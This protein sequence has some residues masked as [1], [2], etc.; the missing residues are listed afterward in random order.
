MTGVGRLRAVVR[1]VTTAP[2]LALIWC[3]QHLISPMT[4]PTCRFY[5]S[6]SSYAVTALRRFG[7]IRGSWLTLCRVLRCN[8]WNPGGVD[9]VPHREGD[10]GADSTG[11]A[12]RRHHPEPTAVPSTR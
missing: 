3:Y 12:E 10:H 1:G 9:H 11:H 8:P 6:C 2:L 4:P 5:P 7:L